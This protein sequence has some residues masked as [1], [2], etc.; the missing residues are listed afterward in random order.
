LQ[1]AANDAVYLTV[2]EGG[3]ATAAAAGG[4]G[5]LYYLG[6][7]GIAIQGMLPASV[8]TEEGEQRQLQKWRE[9]HEARQERERFAENNPGVTDARAGLAPPA[10]K[11]EDQK[12][13]ITVEADDGMT[14]DKVPVDS[15]DSNDAYDKA[16]DRPSH[17]RKKTTETV[18]SKARRNENGEFICPTCGVDIP[19]NRV[20][21]TK[22][23]PK[24]ERGHHFDHYPETNAEIKARLKEEWQERDDPPTLEEARKEYLN[25]YQNPDNLRVQCPGC[26][27]SHEFEGKKGE[28]EGE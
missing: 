3:K 12:A 9:L 13:Q 5:L 4:R 19:K 8:V 20:V 27:I 26:N 2:V 15:P 6:P 25:E 22:N 28:F 17:W 23:G 14:Q 1:A 11:K 21:Q 16:L 10:P 7:I 24:T 18:E